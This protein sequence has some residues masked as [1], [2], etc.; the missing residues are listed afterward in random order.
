MD[1]TNLLY[2]NLCCCIIRQRHCSI[3]R[4][5]YKT[6]LHYKTKSLYCKIALFYRITWYH[7]DQEIYFSNDR[8]VELAKNGSLMLTVERDDHDAGK[9]YCKASNLYGSV[10]GHAV[11]L[12]FASKYI[13]V[14][15]V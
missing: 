2:Y 1:K 14:S 12:I 13:I 8:S 5:Q 10:R 11:Q 4:P 6:L 7:N 15:T 3:I 9:Y